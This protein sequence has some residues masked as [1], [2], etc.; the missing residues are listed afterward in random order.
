MPELATPLRCLKI[1]ALDFSRYS[2]D[3]YAKLYVEEFTAW[4]QFWG[5]IIYPLLKR[6]G[7]FSQ[8][9]PMRPVTWLFLAIG[10]LVK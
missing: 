2:W 3:R 1:I 10:H 9:M 4:Q 8:A 7:Y 6:L 5:V